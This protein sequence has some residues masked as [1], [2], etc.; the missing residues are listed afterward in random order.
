[1]AA[2]EWPN[3][4]ENFWNRQLY[5]FLMQNTEHYKPPVSAGANGPVLSTKASN[6]V[7]WPYNAGTPS[8]TWNMSVTLPKTVVDGEMILVTVPTP[9][10]GS[11]RTFAV[12]IYDGN[13]TLIT[14]ETLSL[15][16]P[17]FR[18]LKITSPSYATWTAPRWQII[19]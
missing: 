8:G 18:I 2:L 4:P 1:M 13:N 9:Y 3:D 5:E 10:Y 12:A 6:H 15:T 7:L 19:Q 16:R 17:S 11:G 14:T